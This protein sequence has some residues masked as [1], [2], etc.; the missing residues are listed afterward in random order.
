MDTRALGKVGPRVSAVG[1]GC[2]GMSDLYGPA[3]RAESL[4]TIHA[5]S[6][7]RH[8]PRH[9]RLLRHRPQRAAPREALAGRPRD[10][11]VLSVKFGALRDVRG[12]GP[13]RRSPGRGQELPRLHAAAAGHRPRRRLPP[14]ARRPGGPDRGDGRRHRGDGEGRATCGTSA[15][16]RWAPPTIRRADAVHPISDLQIEY[17]L[18]SRGIEDEIL[19]TTRE[20]GIAI[21][22]YGVLSRGLLSGHWSKE[23]ALAEGR[24]PRPG[25][26]RF[27]GDEPRAQPRPRRGAGGARAR[28]RDDD[29]RPGHRVGPLAG[30]G[31]RPPRRREAARPARR[32]AAR[33]R[34]SAHRGRPRAA[35]SRGPARRRRGRPLPHAAHGPPRQRA[36]LGLAG[37][38][39]AEQG[40][41]RARATPGS[42]GSGGAAPRSPPRSPPSRRSTIAARASCAVTR[43]MRAIEA[44]FTPSRKAPA[45]GERRIRG[46]SGPLRATKTKAGRKMPTVATDRAPEAAEE[47][48]DERGGREDRARRD[49]ADRDGVEELALGQPAAPHDEVGAQEGEQHVAAAEEDRADLQEDEEEGREAERRDAAVVAARPAAPSGRARTPFARARPIP[50][51]AQATSA[52]SAPAPKITASSW[53]PAATAASASSPS[54]ARAACGWRSAPGSTGPAARSR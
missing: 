5:A 20:L 18:V 8:A 7:R 41:R 47:I 50:T 54:A 53:T 44:T 40:R 15:S 34:G 26:P 45:T 14:H 2:M 22:A 11:F 46:T 33:A 32:V 17:S 43:A 39:E 27:E 48:A 10:A 24:L 19:P 12:I 35:R 3:D 31:R 1:L 28:E 16:P 29:R 21:T 25:C 49:L 51:R 23:R 38:D 42:R 4:A 36:A 6:T 13:G 52:A 30:R 9:R 37:E